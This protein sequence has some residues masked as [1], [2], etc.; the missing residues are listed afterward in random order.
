MLSPASAAT[1]TAAAGERY[2]TK[3]D[4]DDLRHHHQLPQGGHAHQRQV[5]TPEFRSRRLRDQAPHLLRQVEDSYLL[6]NNNHNNAAYGRNPGIIRADQDNHANEQDGERRGSSSSSTMSHRFPPSL[7][8]FDRPEVVVGPLL[9]VG[10]FCSVYEVELLELHRGDDGDEAEGEE[11]EEEEEKEELV[12][13]TQASVIGSKKGSVNFNDDDGCNNIGGSQT[14]KPRVCQE[15]EMDDRFWAG[16]KR[17]RHHH[18]GCG[19]GGGGA[20]SSVTSLSSSTHSTSTLG[21]VGNASSGKHPPRRVPAAAG[22]RALMKVRA[23]RHRLHLP[24]AGGSGGD[25]GDS[26]NKNND[27]SR[28]NGEA[29][30]AIKMLHPETLSEFERT[31][32]M[33]DLAMEAMYL[34]ALSHPNI[35]TCASFCLG[36]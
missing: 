26:D 6:R 11:E 5:V 13:K 27:E 29:R 15:G 12:R 31:R 20:S 1:A 23:R 25:G 3:E 24:S 22:R 19:G 30:Y 32:G 28:G 16:R 36:S 33:I 8:T 10:G 21:S 14:G 18:S 35:S 9:G 34:S 4:Y 7:P 2:S 17:I